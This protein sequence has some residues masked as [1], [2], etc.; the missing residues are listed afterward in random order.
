MNIEEVAHDTPEKITT[1]AIDPAT[2]LTTAD[3]GEGHRA[4]SGST[5]ISPRR[6]APKSARE[7]ST[8]RS[9]RRT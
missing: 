5:V 8:T 4:R 6:S 1:V 7:R 9:W 3:H 2:G